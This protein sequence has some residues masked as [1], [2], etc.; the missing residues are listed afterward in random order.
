MS[1][2][3]RAAPGLTGRGAGDDAGGYNAAQVVT[4]D[5]DRMNTGGG[6]EIIY[7][8]KHSICRRKP[9]TRRIYVSAFTARQ[10]R[11]LCR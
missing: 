1:F 8:S 4:I 9:T 3:K 2:A 10:I 5:I 11:D 6:F 7:D